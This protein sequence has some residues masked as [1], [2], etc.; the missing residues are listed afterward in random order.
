[1][2][3]EQNNAIEDGYGQIVESN[4]LTSLSKVLRNSSWILQ[5]CALE[6]IIALAEYGKI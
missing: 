4:A 6:M 3:A 2:H 1:M 5:C